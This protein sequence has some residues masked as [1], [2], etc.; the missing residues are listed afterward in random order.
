[1]RHYSDIPDNQM[2]L[3]KLLVVWL[4][5]FAMAGCSSNDSP[6]M[7]EIDFRLE[8]AGY[9]VTGY[10]GSED[11]IIGMV[12]IKLNTKITLTNEKGKLSSI[13]YMDTLS[14]N[15][16]T[17]DV[18]NDSAMSIVNHKQQVCMYDIEGGKQQKNPSI[19]DQKDEEHGKKLHDD[20]YAF[21]KELDIDV[22]ELTQYYNW[23]MTD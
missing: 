3:R 17:I 2:K 5:C 4:L 21:L 15:Q 1:M 19:C 11:K 20:F 22:S 7:E 12:I 14:K 6:S 18:T 16:Y 13:T 23:F 9:E 8:N 10:K